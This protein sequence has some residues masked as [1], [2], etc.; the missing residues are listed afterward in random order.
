MV[1]SLDELGRARLDGQDV[2]Y[3]TTALDDLRRA[4][5]RR[6]ALQLEAPSA[7]PW[8][9]VA[10]AYEACAQ[11]GLSNLHWKVA[12]DERPALR[13]PRFPARDE[14]RSGRVVISVADGQ[15]RHRWEPTLPRRDGERVD[16]PLTTTELLVFVREARARRVEVWIEPQVPY[17][18]AWGTL[19]ALRDTGTVV[20]V[21]VG[22]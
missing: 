17:G 18:L 14:L 20:A 15:A 8:R 16:R 5:G 9:D 7:L 22:R 4:Q 3:L 11:V 21:R 1:L 10:P 19:E 2:S 12:G 6:V 13:L